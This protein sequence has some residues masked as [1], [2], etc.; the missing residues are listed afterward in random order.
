MSIIAINSDCIR[1][2]IYKYKH[3]N[4]FENRIEQH[5]E[6]IGRAAAQT[7]NEQ[8]ESER[9]SISTN[10]HMVDYVGGRADLCCCV[11][12]NDDLPRLIA[13]AVYNDRS[14][15]AHHLSCVI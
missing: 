5:R 8:T 1:I 14:A 7:N 3:N 2:I 11:V 15:Y 9:E 6:K 4:I 13:C 10:E 12:E